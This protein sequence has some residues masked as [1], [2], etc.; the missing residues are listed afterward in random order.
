MYAAPIGE[1]VGTDPLNFCRGHPVPDDLISLFDF[2]FCIPSLSS[3]LL[4][5]IPSTG[6]TLHFIVAHLANTSLAHTLSPL[7]PTDSTIPLFLHPPP[8]TP[9]SQTPRCHYAR[10]PQLRAFIPHAATWGKFTT[11]I[12]PTAGHKAPWCRY[13]GPILARPDREPQ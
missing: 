2:V 3:L 9:L 5:S 8:H 13:L 12:V 6:R 7:S 11:A 4:P 1:S 10:P